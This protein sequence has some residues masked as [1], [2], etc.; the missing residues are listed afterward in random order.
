[1]SRPQLNPD[2]IAALRGRV[3]AHN[4]AGQG[5]R[6]RLEELRKVFVGGWRGDRPEVA[7]M[8]AVDRHLRRLSKANR[9]ADFSD[10]ATPESDLRLRERNA[11]YAASQTQVIPETRFSLYGPLAGAAGG[12]AV[13]AAVGARPRLLREL[14][15]DL[16][17]RAAG[18]VI[19]YVTGSP[20]AGKG[21]R[22]ALSVA[23][24][25]VTDTL[26]AVPALYHRQSLR[27]IARQGLT[28]EP[29]RKA[30]TRRIVAGSLIGAAFPG[31]ALA[32]TG[33][34]IGTVTGPYL[35]AAS[36]RRVEKLAKAAVDPRLEASLQKAFGGGVP[37]HLASAARGLLESSRTA[38]GKVLT[39][40]RSRMGGAA[41]TAAEAVDPEKAKAAAKAA[42][43]AARKA[44]R[45][46]AADPETWAANRA[47]AQRRGSGPFNN[48]TLSTPGRVAVTGAAT[49]AGAGAGFAAEKAGG[50]AV[51]AA[52]R[53]Y[54]RDEDGKFTSK[55]RAVHTSGL[56]GAAIGGIVGAVLGGRAMATRN[57]R[58]IEDLIS[59]Q[60]D[61][62]RSRPLVGVKSVDGAVDDTIKPFAESSGAKLVN[63]PR[64][65]LA[66]AKARQGWKQ[67]VK[68][69]EGKLKAREA[70]LRDY[71]GKLDA[72]AKSDAPEVWAGFKIHA[73]ARD[74]IQKRLADPEF[75]KAHGV[76]KPPKGKIDR[77]LEIYR[78][79]GDLGRLRGPDSPIQLSDAQHAALSDYVKR[80][81]RAVADYTGRIQSLRDSY[82][83]AQKAHEKAVSQSSDLGAR[84]DE[85]DARLQ[86]LNN[87]EIVPKKGMKGG[88]T[89]TEYTEQTR[90]LS[91]EK[92]A[93]SE[94][95]AAAHATRDAMAA[96]SMKLRDT[97]QIE[98]GK[99]P[100]KFPTALSPF[101]KEPIP[102]LPDGKERETLIR[103][104][105]EALVDPVHK[106]R[107]A[108]A[109][110]IH[111]A[112]LDAHDEMVAALRARAHSEPGKVGRAARRLADVIGPRLALAREDLAAVG[113]DIDKWIEQRSA[114]GVGRASAWAKAQARR[115]AA[116]AKDGA[117][118]AWN[119]KKKAL[120][121]GVTAAG[122]WG[123]AFAAAD[124]GQDGS[125]DWQ[126]KKPAD[127]KTAYE[128][129]KGGHTLPVFRVI[130]AG[131]SNQAVVHGITAK[132]RNGERIFVSGTVTY[133]D[134]KSHDIPGG[135]TLKD[136]L[137]SFNSN[138]NGGG[139]NNDRLG[140]LASAMG[141]SGADQTNA[142]LGLGSGNNSPFGNAVK[143]LFSSGGGSSEKQLNA[144]RQG[145]HEM[146]LPN[147]EQAQHLREAVKTI[148]RH[149]PGSQK[150]SD[151]HR[152]ELLS[153]I[154]SRHQKWKSRGSDQ[155][156]GSS[157]RPFDFS[158]RA[159]AP[160]AKP[161]EGAVAQKVP[162]AERVAMP[163][164]A[165]SYTPQGRR[166]VLLDE[167]HAHYQRMRDELPSTDEPNRALPSFTPAALH[168][169]FEA[170]L[171]RAGEKLPYGSDEQKEA[172]AA[173][174]V[175]TTMRAGMGIA[176]HAEPTP[177]FDGFVE[178]SA[179]SG[180]L[181]KRGESVLKE[182]TGEAIEA[183]ER[184]GEHVARH[185][186]LRAGAGPKTDDRSYFEPVR[187]GETVGGALGSQIGIDSVMRWHKARMAPR[188]AADVASGMGALRRLGRMS[189]RSLGGLALGL[190]ASVVG[191]L[192]LGAAGKGLGQASYA[193]RGQ[194]APE[195]WEPPA[196]SDSE[197][198]H[199]LVGNVTGSLLGS[200]IK[201]P[202]VALVAGVGAQL[203]G[204]ELGSAA[205][206][207]LNPQAR[208]S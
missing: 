167:L 175:F 194:K 30:N 198:T 150:L 74:L 48:R 72:A 104:M 118:W 53:V 28:G 120:A 9:A 76:A 193:V 18:Q 164:P 207:L 27:R 144:L 85:I 82:A 99:V 56:T 145:I 170:K 60:Y 157:S 1:M 105:K 168:T 128:K 62:F 51:N 178:K 162:E 64:E 69:T 78:Q 36:P 31:A 121:T 136:V 73:E 188:N 24:N 65:R 40:A 152:Q 185:R 84:L 161:D 66:R 20:K 106:E 135:A 196:R 96:E 103:A 153:L 134:G 38:A 127:V 131:K 163:E 6:T 15:T 71:T 47:S 57:S 137:G 32:H 174:Q 29:K 45:R 116:T 2:T 123:T 141:K 8:S 87:A 115:A 113:G 77:A 4:E 81:D 98:G 126:I 143:N 90:A 201:R 88:I 22:K 44:T 149:A 204:E 182:R 133:N 5:D 3:V 63:S 139:G 129:L 148:A 23:T 179:R 190:G 25:A 110:K 180:R 7:A 132:Q 189:R 52:Q 208:R 119:N 108:A 187:F 173:R 46:A 192:A 54:Y 160:A 39:A 158:P 156:G 177:R 41:A 91:A 117:T 109:A 138:S 61:G 43:D 17:P 171:A 172:W 183:I 147:E 191:G 102:A 86:E 125:L 67:S 202:G 111:K 83:S 155:G 79:E 146:P 124:I 33:W 165:R 154:D 200:A 59:R 181:A 151:A 197:E 70:L 68:D 114:G 11:G 97:V 142:L 21:A 112:T 75:W 16:V 10:V 12:L 49:V 203:A 122:T 19:G 93:L 37:K 159:K 80:A 55:D 89:K 35:D 101:T 34:K 184:T 166:D 130:N 95:Q 206:R 176:Q 14:R 195:G 140:A 42:R 92:Q 94:Q 50:A 199:R 100:R 58:A 26:A 169:L 186:A 205:H 107:L 13:G